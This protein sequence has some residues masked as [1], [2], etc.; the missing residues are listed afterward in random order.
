MEPTANGD[1]QHAPN[2]NL[3]LQNQQNQPTRSSAAPTKSVNML[4]LGPP[5]YLEEL[6][7]IE[8]PAYVRVVK[9]GSVDADFQALS[10]QDFESANSLLFAGGHAEATVLQALWP[11][12]VNLEW[13]HSPAAGI[14][15]LLFPAL[16]DSPVTVTNGKGA[17]SLPLAEYIM[18]ACTY[19]AKD[20]P[21][22]LAN[23]SSSKWEPFVMAELAGAT[24]G[25][26]GFGDIGRCVARLA[27]AYQ[28]K[29]IGLRRRPELASAEE[30]QH[31]DEVWGTDRLLE[32]LSVSDYIVLATPSTAHT[33]GLLDAAA[34]AHV[35]RGAVIVNVA[36][37]DCVDEDAV[38]AALESG[39]V[40]GAA[41]DVVCQEPLPP[42][43]PLWKAPGVLI[44][45]HCAFRTPNLWSR[46]VL[47][48]LLDNITRFANGRPLRNVADKHVGY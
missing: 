9:C 16:C 22:I 39:Q 41:L 13:I 6:S 7:R 14:D 19:F 30:L 37:G 18:G 45:P 36:R 21:R 28:M 40:R 29:V 24:M 47:T 26:V 2:P 17:F 11:K 44:T 4:I 31:A 15:K 35:K 38:I 23:Q 33:R 1:L 20:F 42:D 48:P 27:H 8:L 5:R 43:S 46:A 3:N 12:L 34:L 10:S 25:I 32:L